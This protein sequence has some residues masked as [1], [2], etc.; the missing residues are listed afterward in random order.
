MLICWHSDGRRDLILGKGKK[1]FCI[2]SAHTG[3][4]AQLAS[5]RMGTGALFLGLKRPRREDNRSPSPI[6]EVKNDGAVIQLE[7]KIW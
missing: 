3:S 6:A 5:Y 1:C 4:G 2:H 7:F